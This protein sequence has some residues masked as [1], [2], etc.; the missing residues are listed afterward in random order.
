MILTPFPLYDRNIEFFRYS[1]SFFPLFLDP[2][3]SPSYSL[4]SFPSAP[5]LYV[6]KFCQLPGPF[7]SFFLSACGAFRLFLA[8]HYT[9]PDAFQAFLFRL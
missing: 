2:S 9:A 1:R 7:I 8:E 4:T 3:A 5:F 6:E